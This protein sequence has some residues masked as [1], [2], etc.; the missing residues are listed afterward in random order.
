MAIRKYEIK[1]YN[2]VVDVCLDTRD[3]NEQQ[4]PI[5]RYIKLMF[6]RY[7]IEKEPENCFVVTDDEDNAVGYIL[8]CA[9]YDNYHK[10]MSEYLQ[11]IAE[12]ENGKY[13]PDAYVEMYNHDI[14]KKDYPAHLHI[15]IFGE[16]R[17]HGYGS[18]M[19]KALCD[20]L[21][22]KGIKGVMLIVGGDNER[23]Q[24]F[25][26]R[27]GFTLLNKKKSGYAYGLKL[28]EE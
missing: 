20:H 26:E 14:Y 1:D 5:N 21:K 17:S 15:D 6:C 11:G 8:G 7:Y 9:D 22:S 18:F 25:Y 24:K 10:N 16:Y 2:N 28:T 27:N 4:T 3:P 13:L 23:A 19:I 12:I